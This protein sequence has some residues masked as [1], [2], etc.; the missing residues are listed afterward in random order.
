MIQSNKKKYGQYYTTNCDYIL[1]N[2]TIP[3]CAKLIEPFVGQGDLVKWSKQTAWELYDIDPK[4]TATTQDTLLDPPDYKDKYPVTNPPFLAKNKSKDKRVYEKHGVDDLYKAAVKSF[5]EGD[6]SGGI[7][8]IPLNFFCDRDKNIRNLFF[9]KYNVDEVNVFEETVFDD[10]AY[11]VC[12]F[13]FTRGKYQN[14]ITFRFYPNKTSKTFELKKEH[15]WRAGGEIFKKK[16]SK[17]K[18]GRLLKGHTPSTNIFMIIHQT[19]L[20]VLLL[21]SLVTMI[22]LMSK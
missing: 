21:L 6:V 5:V 11:T 15:G 9:E 10:T 13:Q 4:C 3:K 16:E 8:I 14:P 12:S 7:L 19:N 17:Y 18:L 1:S 2:I 20:I 22:Y